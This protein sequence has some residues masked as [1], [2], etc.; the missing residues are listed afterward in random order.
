VSHGVSITQGPIVSPSLQLDTVDD[1]A[2]GAEEVSAPV[3]SI[4]GHEPK[5]Q[6]EILK[7]LAQATTTTAKPSKPAVATTSTAKPTT[8]AAEEEAEEEEE[9]EGEDE[10]EDASEEEEESEE[11][12]DDGLFGLAD[13]V[14]LLGLDT[15]QKAGAAQVRVTYY[16]K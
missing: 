9:S 6:I 7:P 12:E 2:D 15:T 1:L 5:P 16:R 14:E 11:E 3:G 10:D 13:L 8:A 4:E